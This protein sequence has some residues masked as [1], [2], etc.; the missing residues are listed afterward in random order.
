MI[1]IDDDWWWCWFQTTDPKLCQKLCSCATN[2]HQAPKC[3]E[4]VKC[5]VLL[6]MYS[7]TYKTKEDLMCLLCCFLLLHASYSF[8]F[9]SSFAQLICFGAGVTTRR[10]PLNAQNASV[11]S[12][13]YR[14]FMH[15]PSGQWNKNGSRTYHTHRSSDSETG[16]K[17]TAFFKYLLRNHLGICSWQRVPLLIS[18]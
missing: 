8:P 2:W 13:T 14:N 3:G 10:K 18:A 12:K 4:L 16:N 15:K 5:T 9:S 6:H 1:L 7:A 17:T 11:N